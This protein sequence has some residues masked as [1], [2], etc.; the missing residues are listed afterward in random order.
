M[1]G[2]A[3]RPALIRFAQKVLGNNNKSVYR[4]YAKRVLMKIP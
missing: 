4:G 1:R 3:I 2:T